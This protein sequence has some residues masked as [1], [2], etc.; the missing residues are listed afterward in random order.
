MNAPMGVM[1]GGLLAGS[2]SNAGGLGM[3]GGSGAHPGM[4]PAER[5]RV[6]IG[7]CRSMTRRAFGVGFISTRRLPESDRLQCEELQ[8]VA[9]D[10]GVSIIMHSFL[11]PADLV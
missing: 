9:L 7:E 3:I 2:V 4:T 11:V 5:L 1:A 10:E 6:E 8:A